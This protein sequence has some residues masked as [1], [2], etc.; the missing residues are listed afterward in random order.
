MNLQCSPLLLVLQH[1]LEEHLKISGEGSFGS[2]FRG[3]WR[4]QEVSLFLFACLR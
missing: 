3:E 1:L 2:V 4:G